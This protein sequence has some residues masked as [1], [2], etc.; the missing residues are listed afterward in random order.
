[1]EGGADLTDIALLLHFSQEFERALAAGPFVA[2]YTHIVQQIV[3]EI[4]D[5][6]LPHLFFEILRVFRTVE[7]PDDRHLIGEDEGI[8]RMALHQAL[9]D[10]D[11]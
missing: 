4:V 6:G 10:G 11:L 9:A 5:T 7:D 8:A 1:M 2:V 3:I